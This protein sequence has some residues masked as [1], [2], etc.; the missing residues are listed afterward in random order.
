MPHDIGILTFTLFYFVAMNSEIFL[1]C[2]FGN[3]V[4]LKS[5]NL[6]DEIYESNWINMSPA[7]RK[8]IF[9]FRER[10]KTSI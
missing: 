9:V 6:M 1:P 7:F 5:L 4:I 2:Y 10:L 3:E 8:D